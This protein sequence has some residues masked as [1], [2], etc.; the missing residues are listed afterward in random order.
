MEPNSRPETYSS[1]DL[2]TYSSFKI[3]YYNDKDWSA[4]KRGDYSINVKRKKI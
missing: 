1:K 4:G 3:F 2:E